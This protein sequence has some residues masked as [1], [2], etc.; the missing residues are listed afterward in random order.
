MS[1]ALTVSVFVFFF[2]RGGYRFNGN[3]FVKIRLKKMSC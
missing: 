2:K 1:Y 3:Q